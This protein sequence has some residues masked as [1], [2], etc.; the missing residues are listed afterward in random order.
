[1]SKL[2]IYQYINNLKP[3]DIKDFGLKQN[4]VL[5][6][7]E[8]E[9]IYDYIKHKTK[10]LF[11]NPLKVIAEIKDKVSIPVYNKILELY[12]HYKNILN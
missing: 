6:E 10:E 1:M 2:F 4:I 11:N 12:N 8:I 7:Q 9:I 3:D 5:S